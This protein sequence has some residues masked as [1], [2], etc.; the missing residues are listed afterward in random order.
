[1]QELHFNLFKIKNEI[2]ERR[3]IRRKRMNPGKGRGRSKWPRERPE[4]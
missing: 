4:I 3:R 2:P 1:M